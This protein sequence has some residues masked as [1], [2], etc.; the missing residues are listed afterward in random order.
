[1]GSHRLLLHRLMCCLLFLPLF[2]LP[3]QLLEACDALLWLQPASEGYN[4]TSGPRQTE[5]YNEEPR[6]A[7][8]NYR[9]GMRWMEYEFTYR[10]AAPANS[11]RSAQKSIIAGMA[12]EQLREM[13]EI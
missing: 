8:S 2:G 13:L 9:H 5:G 12:L 1:M 6:A 7:G 11:A 4:A 3:Y 10:S